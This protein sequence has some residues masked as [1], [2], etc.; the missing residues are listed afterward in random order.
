MINDIF[1][2]NG[3]TVVLNT[4]ADNGSEAEHIISTGSPLLSSATGFETSR[5]DGRRREI[6]LRSMSIPARDD[7]DTPI[8][9]VIVPEFTPL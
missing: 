5:G 6:S 9:G 7:A 3:S 2:T 1:P 8:T 4:K